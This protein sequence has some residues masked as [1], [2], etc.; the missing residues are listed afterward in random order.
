MSVPL[1]YYG[2]DV[3]HEQSLFLLY[4]LIALEEINDEK[5]LR[6]ELRWIY[7][8][9]LCSDNDY[10]ISKNQWLNCNLT[11]V[12]DSLSCKFCC[13]NLFFNFRQPNSADLLVGG[14][15]EKPLRGSIFGPTFTCILARQ[16]GN[17]RDSD[18]F[19]YENDLPPTSFNKGIS[20]L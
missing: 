16:F 5:N 8:L 20:L 14:L 13:Y 6:F 15:L 11:V 18:R 7:S 2:L 9:F 10:V 12:L 4:L 1:S 17:I 3:C 19:W